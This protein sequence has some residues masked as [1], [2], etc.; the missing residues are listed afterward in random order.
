MESRNIVLA[1][2]ILAIAAGVFYMIDPTLGG[3]FKSYYNN[4]HSANRHDMDTSGFRSSDLLKQM[5]D[6][7]N[8]DEG[9]RDYCDHDTTH[10]QVMSDVLS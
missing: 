6:I 4:D 2:L 3:L 10:T 5:C 9:F 7:F 1:V 8:D